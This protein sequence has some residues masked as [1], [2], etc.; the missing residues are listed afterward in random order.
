MGGEDRDQL[1]MNS[2]QGTIDQRSASRD[3]R[4]IDLG[5]GAVEVD[6]AAIDDE[7]LAGSVRGVRG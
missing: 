2:G 4:G 6:V 7:V 1:S 5:E 3:V